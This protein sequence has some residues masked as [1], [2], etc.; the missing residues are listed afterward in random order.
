MQ[1]IKLP[2]TTI[3]AACNTART[4]SRC[5]SYKRFKLKA[6]AQ[7]N[8]L[9]CGRPGRFAHWHFPATQTPNPFTFLY[10][11]PTL[12]RTLASARGR[13]TTHNN[14]LT[15]ALHDPKR[16]SPIQQQ[17]RNATSTATVLQADPHHSHCNA[18]DM[19]KDPIL[20]HTLPPCCLIHILGCRGAQRLCRSLSLLLSRQTVCHVE[21]TCSVSCSLPNC[22]ETAIWPPASAVLLH[23][24]RRCTA[25]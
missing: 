19:S 24:Q 23:K 8:G 12:S 20:Q 3:A 13:M 7:P 5:K 25:R 15:V 1:G 6:R 22:A 17:G 11:H 18:S 14:L 10:K 4:C 9:Q 2:S 16:C 21:S